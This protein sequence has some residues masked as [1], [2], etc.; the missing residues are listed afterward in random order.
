MVMG[1]SPSK[2]LLSTVL[3]LFPT[4]DLSIITVLVQ[5]YR[6]LQGTTYFVSLSSLLVIVFSLS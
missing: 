1:T 2:T 6:G 4:H 3:Q 5:G